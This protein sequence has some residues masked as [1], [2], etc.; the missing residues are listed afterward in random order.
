MKRREI[1]RMLKSAGF[2]VEQRKRHLFWTKHG[3]VVPMHRGDNVDPRL[4]R[5]ARSAIRRAT[6]AEATSFPLGEPGILH[7]PASN[8][9]PHIEL[10]NNGLTVHPHDNGSYSVT[11]EQGEAPMTPS[12]TSTNRRPGTPKYTSDD[13]T[14]VRELFNQGKS[15]K[16]I[17][18]AM[19]DRLT[20]DQPL[21]AVKYLRQQLHLK[22]RERGVLKTAKQQMVFPPTTP[23]IPTTKP[24][25]MVSVTIGEAV[26]KVSKRTAVA[27]LEM[28]AGI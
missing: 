3:I 24:E 13:H 10:W 5:E 12:T 26:F 20:N 4:E 6:A 11:I 1:E 9:A 22:R 7:P 19:K 14:R 16:E 17:A 15:D 8:T 21:L 18:D 27:I 28:L 23:L 25:S 2:I